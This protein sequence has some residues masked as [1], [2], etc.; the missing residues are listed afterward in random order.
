MNAPP[1]FRLLACFLL[2]TAS[3]VLGAP[4]PVER[5][6][7]LRVRGN[8]IVDKQG[9][10]VVLRGM[11]LFWSQWQG[12]FYNAEAIRWLR[13]DWHCSVVRVALGVDG[14]GFLREPAR[15]QA[16]V[17]AVVDAAIALGLYVIIDWHDHR[18]HEHT[19]QATAFF[20]E[21]ARLYGDRPNVIYELWNEP[22]QDHDW[23]KR[24]KPWHETLVAKI[25]A[26][27]PDNLIV[28]GTQ[29]W[30]QD[31][32]KAAADPVRGENLAYTLHFY[33]GTH[34]G[35]LR[36]KAETALRSGVALFVTEWGTGSADGNGK[37]DEA[38]TR[39]W[40]E[41][42]ERHQLSWCNW[43]VADKAETT[44]AL[45]PGAPANGNW[46]AEQRSPSGELVRAE[47]RAKN[48]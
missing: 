25:R 36:E 12:Q 27:D 22:L 42:M 40:W 6:G 8:R 39:L 4:T 17:R 43:S 11:S 3:V 33:A 24:I 47:L 2:F 31:V 10:P 7:Q 23:S 44:A 37:L 46:S 30:S 26:V 5:H 19:A 20:E 21:M 18:A 1:R 9:D 13:D 38:E 41:F 34:R 14:G 15:E 29:T 45:K 32:D 16:K 48:P 28:L 35:R